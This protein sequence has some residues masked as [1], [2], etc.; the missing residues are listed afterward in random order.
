MKNKEI[1]RERLLEL[2]NG[3][4]LTPAKVLKDAASSTS[5]LHDLFEWDDNEAARQY[6]LNQARTLI[7]SFEI[8]VTINQVEVNVQEFV[9]DPS[10]DSETQGYVKVTSIQS[11]SDEAREFIRRELLTARSYVNKTEHFAA[12]L[13][14]QKDVRSLSNRLEQ[15]A[16]S[17]S[18]KR[19]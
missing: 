10:K 8:T 9:R 7:S 13:G 2:A 18:R 16:Q 17:L 11:E 6:R 3:G 1:I 14:I 5:P 19:K 15:V 12:I 4:Q